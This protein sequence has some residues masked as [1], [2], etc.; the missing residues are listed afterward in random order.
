MN[1]TITTAIGGWQRVAKQSRHSVSQKTFWHGQ[2]G[3]FMA[4]RRAMAT[5]GQCSLFSSFSRL[6]SGP[7]ISSVPEIRWL[8]TEIRA[9]TAAVAAA[10]ASMASEASGDAAATTAA[11]KK[12]N[13]PNVFL[14]NLG[15]IFLMA[16]GTVIV[17]LVRSSYNTSNR[18]IIRDRLEQIAAMDPKE[19]EEFREANS[20]LTLGTMRELL[21]IYYKEHARRSD[22][23]PG[24]TSSYKEF[25]AT[26]R[27]VMA[28]KFPKQGES[29][30]IQMGHYLDR[31]VV[32]IVERRAEKS[33]SVVENN[34]ELPV[35]LLF[36]A[37][38]SAMNGTVSDRIQILHELLLIEEQQQEVGFG[39]NDQSSSITSVNDAITA[40]SVALTRVRDMVGYLQETWQLPPDTQ[41]VPTDRKYPTQLWSRAT[42][43]DML[44]DSSETS[45][46]ENNTEGSGE[47]EIVD[48]VDF[49]A[50]LRRKSVCAWGEC[51]MRAKPGADEFEEAVASGPTVAGAP[52]VN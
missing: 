6:Q 38:I 32:D 24:Y 46:N 2:R 39:I 29:F 45:E 16:I 40:N 13:E 5:R 1:R 11:N 3:S 43:E 22:Y 52:T 19:L 25:V 27:K 47:I 50:I 51:Y 33:A 37:M 31:I 14:D 23:G 18:N 9:Q 49:A 17:T 10:N 42:P 28:T 21:S 7:A 44:P 15:K 12:A 48:L 26:I 35:A 30:T 20:D 36:T 4:K 41:I 8:S 34:E